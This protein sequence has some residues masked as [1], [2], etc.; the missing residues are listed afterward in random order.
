MSSFE[1][2]KVTNIDRKAKTVSFPLT[3]SCIGQLACFNGQITSLH[4]EHTKIRI[5]EKYSFSHCYHLQ[6][7][8]FPPC[9]EEI[10][11]GSFQRCHS[12]K[13]INFG[14]DSNLKI[15]GPKAFF[16][17]YKLLKFEFPPNIEVIGSQAFAISDSLDYIDL[18]GTKVRYIGDSAFQTKY[19]KLILVP[20]SIPA[21]SIVNNRHSDIQFTEKKDEN[22][23]L[24]SP[25]T[26]LIG[27]KCIRRVLIRRGIERISACCFLKANVVSLTIPA[28]VK[29]ICESS[30]NNCSKLKRVCF[31]QNSQLQEIKNKAF[32]F[33]S[34]LEKICFP[35]SLK[36]I[37]SEAFYYCWSLEKVSFPPN[38]QLVR[39]ENAFPNSPIKKLSLPPYV[40]EIVDVVCLMK[41]LN[42]V[43]IDNECYVSNNEGTAIY[44]RDGSELVCVIYK[45]KSFEI[46]RTVR[47]IKKKAFRFSQITESISIPSSVEV[48]ENKAFAFCDNLKVIEFEEG[49]KLKSL[50]NNSLPSLEDIIINNEN[51]IK[52]D[53]GV[54]ISIK[55]RG[56]VFVPSRLT[57]MEIDPNVEIIHSFAFYRSNI[58]SLHFPK[59]LKKIC[60]RAFEGSKLELVIFE[61]GTELDYIKN[62]AFYKTN[63]IEIKLPLIKEK[64]EDI[65]LPKVKKIEFPS[66]FRPKSFSCLCLSNAQTIICPRSSLHTIA[67]IEIY[68]EDSSYDI[69]E[70][71]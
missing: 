25:K 9:L 58:K 7:V 12:L 1:T 47:V 39:I 14:S 51:F 52:R 59:S 10:C 2:D 62:N 54:V 56:I 18:R 27:N 53:D 29:E 69:I 61:E 30:F 20:T 13:H 43:Y 17:C 38:S 3:I 28:S 15:I 24:F 50:S 23:N 35:K 55:P 60:Y 22:R 45:I 37:R 33:C 57:D 6:E 36:I 63:V 70:D 11:E 68:N 44:S 19:K 40:K 31:C 49:S 34:L 32:M 42:Y 64:F 65:S 67:S 5:I 71:E 41:E 16:R 66:N 4:L 46:P 8:E 21:Q 26:L 48:I